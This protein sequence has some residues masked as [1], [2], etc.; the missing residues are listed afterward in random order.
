[1]I[2]KTRKE[3]KAGQPGNEIYNIVCDANKKIAIKKYNKS[4]KKTREKER[5]R[6]S[7]KKRIRKRTLKKLKRKN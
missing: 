7:K 2:V 4:V 6:K 5:K 1:M 3:L